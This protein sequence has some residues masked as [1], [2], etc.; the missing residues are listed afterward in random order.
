M[1][2]IFLPLGIYCPGRVRRS[3]LYSTFRE[4]ILLPLSVKG[5]NMKLMWK[6][7][8]VS[9]WWVQ[10]SIITFGWVLI[11]FCLHLVIDSGGQLMYAHYFDCRSCA[12]VFRYSCTEGIAMSAKREGQSQQKDEEMWCSFR[13]IYTRCVPK[14]MK[15][16]FLPLSYWSQPVLT[17]WL[18]WG[19]P[20]SS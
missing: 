9:I 1:P 6:L 11:S 20:L 5:N 17:G 14:D 16:I 15:Y 8:C 19:G 18:R 12:I 2:P 10:R 13:N 4:V 3:P 7:I